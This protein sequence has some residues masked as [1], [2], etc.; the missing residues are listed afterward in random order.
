MKKGNIKPFKELIF[1]I[2]TQLKLRGSN[3]DKLCRTMGVNRN[4]INQLTEGCRV[5]KIIS[6]ANR[7]GCKPS[8]LLEG[9]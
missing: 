9:L 5:S 8:E 2:K 1:N 3:V 7:I 6:I 4:Y